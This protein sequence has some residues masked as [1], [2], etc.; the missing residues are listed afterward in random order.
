M[1]RESARIYAAKTLR[2][3]GIACMGI[4]PATRNGYNCWT[5]DELAPVTKFHSP[6]PRAK[7]KWSFPNPNAKS[8]V[9][10]NVANN[11]AVDDNLK[12]CRVRYVVAKHFSNQCLRYVTTNVQNK[13]RQE[14]QVSRHIR[15]SLGERRIVVK[16]FSQVWIE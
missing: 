6:R 11:F 3:Q 5:G 1:P 16:E 15:R 7:G 9:V 4:R 14:R 10:T 8:H 2:R 12:P 13:C